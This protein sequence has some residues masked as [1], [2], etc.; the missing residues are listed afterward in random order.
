MQKNFKLLICLVNYRRAQDTIDCLNSLADSANQDF[1]V[2]VCDN[3]PSISGAIIKECGQSLLPN[4]FLLIERPDNPGFAAGNNSCIRAAEAAAVK[5]DLA[6]FL[7]NDTVVQPTCINEILEKVEA[8]PNTTGIIGTTL[9]YYHDRSTVQALGGSVYKPAFGTMKEI[10][11]GLSWPHCVDE[12]QIESQMSYVCGASMLVTSKLLSDIGLM[13]EDYFLFYE[14]IDWCTRA[15][16]FGYSLA[17]ASKAVVYHKEG[18]SIGT[19][20]GT[21][22]SL[23]AE[24]YGISIVTGKQIGRA[25]V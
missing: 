7:N 24:Y 18:A 14:E 12:A 23:L 4:R 10:G 5:F 22:R 2:C 8:S 17:Y 13:A 16:K 20:V 9:L 19:G 21:K 15:K 6:W 3:S 11:N 1:M 25:H